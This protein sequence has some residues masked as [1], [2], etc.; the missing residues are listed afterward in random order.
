MLIQTIYTPDFPVQ[1]RIATYSL[2][3][4]DN[5]I[6]FQFNCGVHRSPAGRLRSKQRL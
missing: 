2:D 3:A 4:D 5:G 6:V 1:Y